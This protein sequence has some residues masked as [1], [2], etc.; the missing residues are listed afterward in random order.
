MRAVADAGP[1]IH[2]SWIDRL[3]LLGDLFEEVLIPG[4]VEREVLGAPPIVPSVDSLRAALATR[5]VNVVQVTEASAVAQLRATT[6]LDPGES[7]AI[8]LVQEV[9]ADLL[10]ID[11]RKGRAYAAPQRGTSALQRS[12]TVNPALGGLSEASGS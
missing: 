12:V 5:L 11:E 4:A 2:L 10:L 1:L 8:V 9:G 6:G 7:E 3:D